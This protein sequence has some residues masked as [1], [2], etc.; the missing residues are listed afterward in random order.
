MSLQPKAGL[1]CLC[2]FIVKER[3]F[4][5]FQII[6]S[7]IGERPGVK[8]NC[9][10]NIL[11]ISWNG[12]VCSPISI[13]RW[14]WSGPKKYGVNA[15]LGRSLPGNS[16]NARWNQTV[17]VVV[18]SAVNDVDQNQDCK[19]GSWY[20]VAD[21]LSVTLRTNCSFGFGLRHFAADH[22]SERQFVVLIGGGQNVRHQQGEVTIYF[23]AISATTWRKF[24][25]RRC[26]KSELHFA[27]LILSGIIVFGEVSPS[28]RLYSFTTND[29][30]P[31][32]I[33]A[34][35]LNYPL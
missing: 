33:W 22:Q 14:K 27:I 21:N 4:H 24:W 12:P 18:C 7:L 10:Q 5:S 2:T 31:C 35:F 15:R 16:K 19:L 8:R 13:I 28:F 34:A 30:P 23:A 9:F 17:P 11:K 1:I 26:P 20:N 32:Y 29:Q 6:P 25:P 3:W